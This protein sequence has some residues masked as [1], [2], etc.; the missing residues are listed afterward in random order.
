[1][2]PL[3]RFENVTRRFGSFTAVRE[4][5]LDLEKGET[6][7]LLGPSGCGKTTLLRM[8][9]GFD[10]PDEGRILLDGRDITHLPPDQRP[11]NTVFQSYA[12]FPHLSIRDN[13]AFGPKLK[14]WPSGEV[15]RETDRMLELVDLTDHAA[16]KPAQLSG[17][18]KQRVAIARALVNK[19]QVLLL[20]E[21]LAALDL[22]L[23][24][25]LLVE[26][27]A[28]HDEVG[29]TFLYVTHDQGEAM[30][31]SDR[32]AVMNQGIIE[33][34]GKPAEIYEAPRSSFVAAFIGDTNFLDGTV[35]TA[36]DRFSRCAL[37]NLGEIVIDNDRT[38]RAGERVHLSL[39]PEKIVVVRENPALSPEE[40]AIHGTVEDVIYFGSRTRY[41][42]RCGC[43]RICA[44]MQ[45]RRYQLDESLP[46]W[47]DAVWLRWHAN[48][49]YLLDR[50]REE[51]E[52]LLTFPGEA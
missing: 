22:K 24:Q 11:V 38:L 26:L 48:D 15:R 39:R 20:D 27:D 6:F 17:G 33:Q 3:L 14:G 46:Q 42:V 19:P 41:W 36:G 23:R 49:G 5:T 37:E 32:I 29:I 7:S 50:Y 18:Q 51:D 34:T 12:L 35:T 52:A 10:R 8:A 31:I 47:G 40:N 45:H 4:L 44:E 9:A 43:W 30:S 25:R 21:P 13:I 2:P 1:M 16:K 28:I